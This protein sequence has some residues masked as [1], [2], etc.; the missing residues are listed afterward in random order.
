MSYFREEDVIDDLR[1]EE[2]GQNST[3]SV[4]LLLI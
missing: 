4:N 1:K 3:F 2:D